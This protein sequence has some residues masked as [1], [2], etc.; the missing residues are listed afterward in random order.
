MSSRLRWGSATAVLEL[1]WSETEPVRLAALELDGR[2]VEM[3]TGVPLVEVLTAS[4]GHTLAS[5]RLVHTRVGA[6]SRYVS[7]SIRPVDG[8]TELEVEVAHPETR[9][10]ATLRLRM[11]DAAPAAFRST[12]TLRNDGGS[13]VVVGSVASFAASLGDAAGPAGSVREWE[14]LRGSSDWLAEARWAHEPLAP[15]FPALREDLTGH[16]PR[17]ELA[18][19]ST[20]TWSTGKHHPAAVV[21]TGA[22]AWAFQV[23]HNGAWRWEIGEDTRA[24]YLALSG[25]TELDHQ[26]TRVL[27]PGQELTTVPASVAVGADEGAALAGLTAYRRAARRPHPDNDAL[28][29]VFNDYMNTLD[30]D[31]T[32]E[33]L[34]P[35]VD[36]AAE[37]GAEVFCIDAGWYDDDGDWWD[38][39]GEWVPST[40]RFPGGLAEVVDRIRDRGMVPGLWLE[41]EVVGVNSPLADTLPAEAFFQRAGARVVEHHRYHLDL[42][43]PAARAHL[44]AVVDRLVAELGVG[45][46]KL[47]YNIDPGAGTDLAADSVGA[48]LLEHNRAHL[49]WLD[50]VLDRHPGLVLENCGSG[51]MR[52]DFA[53]LSRLQLQSTSDQQDPAAYPPIAASSTVAVLPEQAASW[54]YPQPEMSDE[55]IAFTLVTSLSA[56]FYLSG[57]LDRMTSEQKALVAEAVRA[58]KALRTD[59][60]SSYPS[61]PLGLP[62]WDDPWVAGALGTPGRRVVAV[63]S[64]DPAEE[65]TVLALPDLAGA[66]VQVGTVFPATLPEWGTKWDPTSG[67]LTVRN[68]TG[69]V[70]ARLLEV[71][72]TPG[73]TDA[74]SA[75]PSL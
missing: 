43:H 46:L 62:G 20:G 41:P 34:L 42:R 6:E 69:S 39:V 30:G 74:G 12:V 5:A 40:V 18:A 13:P 23:E 37:V 14:L 66:D 70:G 49:A 50:G 24:G 9:L 64:R 68:T 35:L 57:H 67:R 48:A 73:A 53:M 1:G 17:G 26:W 38:S 4:H 16:D 75:I 44:D 51:A 60:A 52:A 11:L 55:E 58:A 27:R 25:P 19:V 54:A 10:G 3:P 29:V 7:H 31:P 36:A 65:E 63:W 72:P 22:L 45:Y 2:R 21:T 59:L 47:D 61:W 56:R 28:A 32:T 8:G 33:R 71:R 15:R